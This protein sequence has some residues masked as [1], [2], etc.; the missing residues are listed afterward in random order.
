MQELRYRH[1]QSN[2]RSFESDGPLQKSQDAIATEFS[3]LF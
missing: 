2:V 3:F 1:D